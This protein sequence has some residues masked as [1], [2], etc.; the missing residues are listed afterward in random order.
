MQISRPRVRSTLGPL[1]LTF[2]QI[3]LLE[4]L[5]ELLMLSLSSRLRLGISSLA[6][7]WAKLG[8]GP[9]VGK[10]WS[11]KAG[12]CL[13]CRLTAL[14]ATSQILVI[15]PL[16]SRSFWL[17]LKMSFLLLSCIEGLGSMIPWK[18]LLRLVHLILNSRLR[19]WSDD[20]SGCYNEEIA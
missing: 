13:V 11:S 3:Y 14:E 9:R 10:R 8:P 17:G 19:P 16:Y 20:S 7:L 1:F 15:P 18:W 5:F 6:A 2:R 4:S 12:R